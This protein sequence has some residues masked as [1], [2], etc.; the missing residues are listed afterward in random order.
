[1]GRRS[2]FQLI[3]FL[4]SLSLLTG[5][6]LLQDVVEDIAQDIDQRIAKRAALAD[7]IRLSKRQTPGQM[8]ASH[9]ATGSALEAR[10][11]AARSCL[12]GTDEVAGTPVDFHDNDREGQPVAETASETEL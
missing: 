5:A 11:C 8:Q 1:M 7:V 4:F 9:D 12:D 6:V 3:P 2:A 10:L